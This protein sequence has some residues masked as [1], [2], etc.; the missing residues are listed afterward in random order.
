[1]FPID[2]VVMGRPLP[3]TKSI[4]RMFK[5]QWSNC[6]KYGYMDHKIEQRKYNHTYDKHS[7]IVYLFVWNIPS[8][9]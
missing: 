3:A 5:C 7:L 4:E 2:D 1:M 9:S 8:G 6:D